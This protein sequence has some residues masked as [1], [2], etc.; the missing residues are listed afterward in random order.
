MQRPT[1]HIILVECNSAHLHRPGSE[2]GKLGTKCVQG[3]C[4]LDEL[5]RG[6]VVRRDQ[7]RHLFR[8]PTPRGIPESHLSCRHRRP[9]AAPAITRRSRRMS[10]PSA[11]PRSAWMARETTSA[12]WPGATVEAESAGTKASPA[13]QNRRRHAKPRP[14]APFPMSLLTPI[15]TAASPFTTLMTLARPLPGRPMGAP[16]CRPRLG[17]A[18]SRLRIRTGPR[19]ASV[20]PQRPIADPAATLCHWRK[21]LP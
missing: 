16:A 21:L 9:G 4:H 11:E 6:R 12:N 17:R 20:L 15:R 2:R 7:P 14:S 3:V 13:Y 10:L 8:L 19:R 18:W 1:P 5:G